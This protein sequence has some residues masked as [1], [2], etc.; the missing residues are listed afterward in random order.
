MEQFKNS[1][2]KLSSKFDEKLFI[3][4][5]SKKIQNNWKRDDKNLQKILNLKFWGIMHT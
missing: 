3:L 5:F 4:L 1:L 2:K